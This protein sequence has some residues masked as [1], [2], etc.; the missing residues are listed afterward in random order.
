MM[1]VMVTNMLLCHLST[2]FEKST[3]QTWSILQGSY[4][5]TV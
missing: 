4:T 3:I 2:G 5:S 1:M